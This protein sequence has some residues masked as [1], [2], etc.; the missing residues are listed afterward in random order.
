MS[1]NLLFDQA[2]A[3]HQSGRMVEAE[4][5]YQHVLQ[6]QPDHPGAL[7]L[8]GVVRQ[9]Q[10]DYEAARELIGR[11]IAI[12][13]RKAV[14]QNNYGAAL[15][16][17]GCHEEALEC[18]A[19]ALGICPAYA[20]ALSNRGMAQASLG[21]D[22]A[23]MA[24]F[25]A[26]LAVQPGHADATRQLASLVR[27]LGMGDEAARLYEETLPHCSAAALAAPFSKLRIFGGQVNTIA[28][29]LASER[30]ETSQDELT[31]DGSNPC[32][33]PGCS[34]HAHVR[35]TGF[36]RSVGSADFSRNGDNGV[37]PLAIANTTQ[38]NTDPT[39][40][41]PA[42]GEAGLCAGLADASGSSEEPAKAWTTN[43][44]TAAPRISVIM[45]VYNAATTIERAIRSLQAQTFPDWE[46]LA[47]DDASGDDSWQMLQAA[48]AA[49]ARIRVSRLEVN[50]GPSAARNAGLRA[51]RGEFIAYLDADDEYHP[52]YLEQLAAARSKG[53]VLMF[54]FDMVYEYGPPR[55]RTSDWDPRHVR[56]IL[57][58]FNPVVPLAAAH[59]RS[60]LDRVG[61]FHE[62]ISRQED[63]DLWKRMARAGAKFTFLPGKSG[64]YHVRPGTLSQVYRLADRQREVILANW[65]AKRPIF[66]L[67]AGM[68]VHKQE[69]QV[70]ERETYREAGE[71]AVFAGAPGSYGFLTKESLHP[72]L[73]SE[74]EKDRV[75][76]IVSVSPHCLVDSTSPT[77]TAVLNGL[78]LLA[79]WG[80]ECQAFCGT[81]QNED[82]QELQVEEALARRKMECSIRNVRIGPFAGRM[83][84]TAQGATPIT[85]FHTTATHGTWRDEEEVAA[86]MTACDLFLKKQRPDAVW[87]Y[88]GDAVSG[89][90]FKLLKRLDIP[91]VFALHD[92]THRDAMAFLPFDY[93]VVPSE[94]ARQH[95]WTTMGL[96]CQ[97]LPPVT[98]TFPEGEETGPP[99][100]PLPEGERDCF[101]RP[102]EHRGPA[103]AAGWHEIPAK[104]GTT[105]GTRT[106][107]R[108]A[109]YRDFFAS[110][111]HQPG[112]P[113]VPPAIGNP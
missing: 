58:A 7:H 71:N 19:L 65:A 102:A 55:S 94:S 50:S 39:P 87:T 33:E 113:L 105:D 104:A 51:A 45:P 47:V 81:R 67:R 78:Q 84:F 76:K 77:A 43:G 110:V 103:G 17:L 57:F 63:W 101:A 27:H 6:Q 22:A 99:P 25:R 26:A 82:G 10:G 20:D 24:S 41:S 56:R 21:Q 30:R 111:T 8:L 75:R 59:R 54:G 80:I 96:A 4:E 91:I 95:Y 92:L 48:A 53:D 16:S 28:H 31:Y 12:N 36:R 38:I 35:S 98:D 72:N 15:Q 40:G 97:V 69:S 5:L 70:R 61:G 18:F 83:T 13:P 29:S 88:G 62:L 68:L 74:E 34:T 3:L 60:L 86:F 89:E 73:H 2:L 90:V 108:A 23:A 1:D 49:D 44:G 14:Y 32:F 64:I 79:G 9:Q 109:I 52:N 100:G 46:A 93:V 42:I 112:P 107:N 11:A 66:E 37:S 106:T 85:L